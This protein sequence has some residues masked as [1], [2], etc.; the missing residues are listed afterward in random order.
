TDE[1]FNIFY[2]LLT[3]DFLRIFPNKNDANNTWF[4]S[5]QSEK[6]F[7]EEDANFV[8]NITSL[9]LTGIQKGLQQGDWKQAAEALEYIHLFQHK[10]GEKVYP[11]EQLVEAELMYNKLNLG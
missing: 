1:R 9:Y 10:A 5:Q 8:K 3:G 11:S 6:G 4:T 2:A 7:E